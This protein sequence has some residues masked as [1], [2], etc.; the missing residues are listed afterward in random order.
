MVALL[1][2][3]PFFCSRPLTSLFLLFWVLISYKNHGAIHVIFIWVI[4]TYRNDRAFSS[5][6]KSESDL[7]NEMMLLS[8]LSVNAR[9]LLSHL[10]VNARRILEGQLSGYIKW[11]EMS[12]LWFSAGFVVF[13]SSLVLFLLSCSF[14]SL[15]VVL[16]SILLVF[17]SIKLCA[18]LKKILNLKIK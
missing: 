7:V 2:P 16:L 12:Y 10:W 15:Y 5:T 8:H 1:K 11:K 14:L 6:S 4:L 17:T 13:C 3:R 18:I 9:K